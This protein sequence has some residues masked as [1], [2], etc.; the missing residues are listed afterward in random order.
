MLYR[1]STGIKS[2]IRSLQMQ[3]HRII[4]NLWPKGMATQGDRMCWPFKTIMGQLFRNLTQESFAWS[5]RRKS[6]LMEQISWRQRNKALYWVSRVWGRSS[7]H[8][9][10]YFCS[11]DISFKMPCSPFRLTEERTRALPG[12]IV[13]CSD[14][15]QDLAGHLRVRQWQ[16]FVFYKWAVPGSSMT[17]WGQGLLK[18]HWGDGEWILSG[19]DCGG[20]DWSGEQKTQDRS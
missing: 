18:S 19:K 4:P 17:M 16:E 12:G 1:K 13:K 11:V 15:T 7:R 14:I 8:L 5:Q 20:R 2:R 9:L 3:Q 10:F 6:I